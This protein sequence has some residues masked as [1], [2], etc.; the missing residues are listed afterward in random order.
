M[1]DKFNNWL[2]GFG[3]DKLLHITVAGWVVAIFCYFGMLSGL[4]GLLIVSLIAI[5]KE[6]KID[7]YKDMIDAY[8]SI[9]GS[10]ISII[11]YIIYQILI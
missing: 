11:F 9:F 5:I 8:W 3:V 2:E 4:I 10:L 6:Q 1:I 7:K